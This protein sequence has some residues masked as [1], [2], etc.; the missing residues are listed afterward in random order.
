MTDN[1]ILNAKYKEFEPSPFHN[2]GVTKC[3]QKRFDDDVG[4]KYFI[5]IN[6]WDFPPHPYTGEQTPTSYEFEA[7]FT[8]D[9]NP[10]N[11]T[12]Y[13]HWDIE[14]AEK[15]LDEMWIKMNLDYYERWDEC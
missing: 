15:F 4:K 1:D 3:F 9:D 11:I 2:S 8:K 10:I 14:T 6:R 7:Y 13:S 12:L 5:D